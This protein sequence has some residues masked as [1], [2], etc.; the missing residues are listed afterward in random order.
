[1]KLCPIE[2]NH[3]LSQK[4]F[5]KNSTDIYKCLDCGTII[6]DIEFYHDQYEEE[7]YY[8]MNQKTKEGVDIEWGFRWRYILSK[9]VQT[10]NPGSLLDVGAGN[11]YFVDLA[12][13]EFSLASTGLEISETEV[14]YAKDVIG[15][16]LINEDIREHNSLYDAVTIFNVIEHVEN[17][18]E[19]LENV[20]SKIKP[21][22][23]LV[24][25]TPNPTCF[26]TK[27]QSL[28]NWNMIYP[29]HHINIF[30]ENALR[31]FLESNGLKIINYETLSTYIN[32]VRN[33]DT[34][35]L[36]LRRMFF[37]ILRLLNLG[38]DHFFIAQKQ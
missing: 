6:A 35:S 25:T 27:V 16:Q 30:T 22:G 36:L 8:T 28:K 18:R 7:S 21:G 20:V 38:A 10:S 26:H 15:V 14:K 11:G 37:Q 2:K 33:I 32:I 19:L 1:M 24:L 34:K 29:P 31:L 23:I 12:A 5:T 17:P 9:I 3:Q 13:R 4:L